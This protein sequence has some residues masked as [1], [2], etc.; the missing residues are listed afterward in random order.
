[1]LD[2]NR[3]KNQGRMEQILRILTNFVSIT[4]SVDL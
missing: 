4:F 1:M 3:R 2:R